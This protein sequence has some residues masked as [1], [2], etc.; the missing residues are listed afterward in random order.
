LSLDFAHADWDFFFLAVKE[1]LVLAFDF[2]VFF[3]RIFQRPEIAF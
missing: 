3:D 2:V 1:D